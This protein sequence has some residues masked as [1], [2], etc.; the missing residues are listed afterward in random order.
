MPALKRRLLVL[1]QLAE[2]VWVEDEFESGNIGAIATPRGTILVDTPMRRADALRWQRRLYEM[3]LGTIYG[4]VNTDYHLEHIM[5]NHVFMPVR[6]FGHHLATKPMAK[7]L[8]SGLERISARYQETDPALA[9][10]ILNAKLYEPE[11]RVGDRIVLHT[12]SREV[13]V[14][15][16]EGHTPAS[17]GVYLP[18]ERILFAGDNVTRNE[19]PIMVEA[20][21]EAWLRT[22]ERIQEMDVEAIVPANGELCDKADIERLHAYIT[23][24]RRRVREYFE[25]GASRRECVEK[26]GMLDWFPVPP[27]QKM[28]ITRRRRESVERVYTETRLALRKRR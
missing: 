10:E 23:E 3:G 19:H 26:V 22:L 4:I 28:A 24:M 15:Y 25:K 16:L 2:G 7:Y 13:H 20:N 1:K 8:T 5:G 6:T 11:I 12:D 17:L 18:Q 21:S 9:Q 14:L 27:D